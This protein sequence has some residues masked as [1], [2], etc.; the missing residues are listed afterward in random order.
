MSSS[1]NRRRG[2]KSL[3][4]NQDATASQK[5]G[6][7]SKKSGDA[8]PDTTADRSTK[9]RD[10]K[11]A[12]NTVR[13]RTTAMVPQLSDEDSMEL[14]QQTSYDDDDAL[15]TLVQPSKKK[16]RNGRRHS[17]VSTIPCFFCIEL[18]FLEIRKMKIGENTV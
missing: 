16:K 7:L 18:I 14:L 11:A 10:A 17:R 4:K 13:R 3:A 1:A 2:K 8:I 12:S 9:P 5:S 6:L 15:Y